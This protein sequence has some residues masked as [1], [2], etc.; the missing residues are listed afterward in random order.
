M[1]LFALP[2]CLQAPVQTNNQHL[3]MFLFVHSQGRWYAYRPTCQESEF[4][5]GREAFGRCYWTH[6]TIDL[7]FLNFNSNII[8]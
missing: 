8:F 4:I 7:I 6:G 5:D 2:K 1:R 3:L